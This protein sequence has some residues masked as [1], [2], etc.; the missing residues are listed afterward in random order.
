[1]PKNTGNYF[2]LMKIHDCKEALRAIVL[3]KHFPRSNFFL[4]AIHCRSFVIH[5]GFL[6]IG[7]FSLLDEKDTS[8]F[9]CKE[10]SCSS[11]L[12]VPCAESVRLYRTPNPLISSLILQN[13]R[14]CW[15][16]F[17]VV[18]EGNN[19]VVLSQACGIEE[20]VWF[21]NLYCCWNP[22]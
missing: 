18:L 7:V 11:F 8:S 17:T 14:L 19:S 10:M 4:L 16:L 6:Q 20:N 15:H 2:H 1:V 12:S 3:W 21:Q 5:G 22:R 9:K 13:D